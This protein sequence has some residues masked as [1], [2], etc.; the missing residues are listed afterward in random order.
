M[1]YHVR[2]F[3]LLAVLLAS[4]AAAQSTTVT[5]NGRAVTLGT[6]TVGGKT[7][8][9]LDQLRAALNAPGGANQQT[10][11]E[12]C[13]N[14]WLFNGIWRMRVT[15]V[16][17]ITDAGRGGWPGIG[18]TVEW[19]NG[20]ASVINLSKTGIEKGTSVAFANGDTW[21][22][23]QGSSWVDAVFKDLPQGAA[24]IM[25][26]KFWLPDSGNKSAPLPTPDKLVVTVD[27]NQLRNWPSL[28]NIR[29]TAANPSFRVN[30]RC[31]K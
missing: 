4:V 9:S 2:T 10:A 16:T 8:V 7:Y 26:Y 18:V 13:R 1:K 6:V 5:I 14:E 21:N 31:T 17:P 19:R 29:Y 30:L 3:G 28:G 23:S 27:P 22:V 20:T 24:N 11:L 15:G 25:Q 12:G